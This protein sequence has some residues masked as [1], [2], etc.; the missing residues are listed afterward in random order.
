M[1]AYT[2]EMSSQMYAVCVIVHCAMCVFQMTILCVPCG[3]LC[4]SNDFFICA[5]VFQ[6]NIE[7]C[8]CVFQM[9]SPTA[10]NVCVSMCVWVFQYVCVLQTTWTTNNPNCAGRHHT[11]RER[12]IQRERESGREEER[13]IR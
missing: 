10:F 1:N 7:P 9:T 4:V 5:C 2:M 8:V 3:C 12:V 11:W 6:M 13:K